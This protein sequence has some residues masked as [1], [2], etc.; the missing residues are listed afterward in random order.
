LSAEFFTLGLLSVIVLAS[1]IYWA[2]ICLQLTNRLMS[3][4]Y[5][6]VAQ[7]DR[8]GR[9]KKPKIMDEPESIYDPEDMRQAEQLNSVFGNL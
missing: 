1:N 8:V 9:E 2:R 6:D 3:R 4:N 5:F 7:G